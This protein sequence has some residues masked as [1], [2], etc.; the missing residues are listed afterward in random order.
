MSE[1]GRAPC[2]YRSHTE[3]QVTTLFTSV[4]Y[5]GPKA[6]HE[7]YVNSNQT[8][9]YMYATNLCIPWL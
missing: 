5:R 8:E 7:V 4:Y 9:A 2:K 3:M 6:L 1:A